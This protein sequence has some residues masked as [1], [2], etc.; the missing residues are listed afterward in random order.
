VAIS[1][2][3]RVAGWIWQPDG[4]TRA[5]VLDGGEL[6]SIG[7]LASGRDSWAK[8][9]NAL[10][11]VVGT[12]Q[13]TSAGDSHAFF[14]DQGVMKDLNDLID[15]TGDG[16]LLQSASGITDNGFISVIGWDHDGI[17]ESVLLTPIRRISGH[18]SLEGVSGAA[19]AGATITIDLRTPGSTAPLETHILA[20]SAAGN[21]EF[22]S[23]LP[24]GSYDVAF[25]GTH[26]LRKTLHNQAIGMFGTAGLS[27]SLA[28]G[29]V[30]GDNLVSLGDFNLLRLAFGSTSS[31]SNWNSAADLNGDGTVSLGDFNLLRHNFGSSG[32]S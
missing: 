25:K 4:A 12:S 23:G 19:V 22:T 16:L 26:W 6:V 7:A 27:V 5:A 30:N 1:S 15:D 13:T 24:P 2:D 31:S 8:G 11:Q 18:V 28:N 29:D 10:G 14:Y 9:I 32:D 17:L 20:P 3:G 21:Y